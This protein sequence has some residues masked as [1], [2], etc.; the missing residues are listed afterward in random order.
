MYNQAADKIVGKQN[1]KRKEK[2]RR[3]ANVNKES[4]DEAH[5]TFFK[6]P[7]KATVTG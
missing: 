5:N 6:Y 3:M 2:R 7:T 4:R 1:D